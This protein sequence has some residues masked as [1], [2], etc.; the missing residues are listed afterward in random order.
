MMIQI[1]LVDGPK[2]FR[3][4]VLGHISLALITVLIILYFNVADLNYV[5]WYGKLSYLATFGGECC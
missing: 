4:L 1:L 2:F 3:D 5:Y